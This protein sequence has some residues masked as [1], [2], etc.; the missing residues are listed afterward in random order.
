ML[1]CETNTWVLCQRHRDTEESQWV[2]LPV[3]RLLRFGVGGGRLGL[4]FI[5][6]D[7]VVWN[8]KKCVYPGMLPIQWLLK[9]VAWNESSA[10]LKCITSTVRS[11]VELDF[12]FH[13]SITSRSQTF[14]EGTIFS[15]QLWNSVLEDKNNI[16]C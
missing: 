10:L 14:A 9:D 13:W 2:H 3:R 8:S 7:L 11:C 15:W 16:E 1:T 5:K 4:T 12:V 6:W